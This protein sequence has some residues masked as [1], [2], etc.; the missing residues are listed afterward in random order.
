MCPHPLVKRLME[1]FL[2]EVYEEVPASFECPRLHERIK[3]IRDNHYGNSELEMSWFVVGGGEHGLL[4]EW[5]AQELQ[6]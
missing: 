1:G 4:V 3:E 2:N 5:K 6:G